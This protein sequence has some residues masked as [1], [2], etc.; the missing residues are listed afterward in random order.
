MLVMLFKFLYKFILLFF[1]QVVKDLKMQ[2]T[3]YPMLYNP[4]SIIVV[5]NLK[6]STKMY[7]PQDGKTRRQ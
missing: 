6:K 2:G 3:K 5:K 1:R 4:M 7:N